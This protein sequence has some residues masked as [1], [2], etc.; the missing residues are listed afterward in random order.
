MGPEIG[1]SSIDQ[2]IDKA[3]RKLIAVRQ[4]ESAHT[5]LVVVD[6]ITLVFDPLFSKVIEAGI[7]EVARNGE[8]LF[9][10]NSSLAI[11]LVILPLPDVR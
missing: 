11:E 2:I 5:L 10:E 6:E 9:I 4:I 7:I 8:R 3:P 1:T